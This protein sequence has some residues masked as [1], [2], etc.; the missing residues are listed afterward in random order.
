MVCR[1]RVTEPVSKSMMAYCWF[2]PEEQNSFE[3]VRIMM[4]ILSEPQSVMHT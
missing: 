4:A 3:K 2:D 1:L